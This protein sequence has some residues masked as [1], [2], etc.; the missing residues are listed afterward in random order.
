MNLYSDAGHSTFLKAFFCTK[1]GVWTEISKQK[2]NIL[3]KNINIIIVYYDKRKL[4]SNHALFCFMDLHFT[5]EVV[6][7]ASAA[8]P[9]VA[10]A[11]SPSGSHCESRQSCHS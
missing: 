8:S 4:I 5:L 6:A 1:I 2:K 9:D 3:D 7:A 11:A 10:A